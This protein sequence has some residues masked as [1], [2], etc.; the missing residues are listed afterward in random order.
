[1]LTCEPLFIATRVLPIMLLIFLSKVPVPASDF[2]NGPWPMF[3]AT[4]ARV[5]Q[6]GLVGAQTCTVA[7]KVFLGGAIT[8]SPIIGPGG[9]IYVGTIRHNLLRIDAATGTVAWRKSFEGAV[10]TITIANAVCSNSQ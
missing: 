5:G 8:G 6:I 9:H 1:V 2:I 3:Q 7:W 10:N 4:A